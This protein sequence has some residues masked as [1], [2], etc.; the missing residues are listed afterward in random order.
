[1][2]CHRFNLKFKEKEN[3]NKSRFHVEL[4][5]PLRNIDQIKELEFRTHFLEPKST[6]KQKVDPISPRAQPPAP[7]A[8]TPWRW[9]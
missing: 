9:A 6:K 1:M 7:R 8:C 5:L 3:N 2:R 4:L